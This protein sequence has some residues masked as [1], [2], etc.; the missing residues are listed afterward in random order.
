MKRK[1]AAILSVIL[2]LCQFLCCA[3]AAQTSD[4]VI[5]SAYWTEDVLYTFVQFPQEAPEDLEVSLFVNNSRQEGKAHPASLRDAG[6][7]VHVMLLVDTSSSMDIYAYYVNTFAQNLMAGCGGLDITV[8]SM[9][10]EFRIAATGLT[11]WEDAQTTL[12]LLDYRYDGSDICGGTAKALEYL[13]EMDYPAGELCSLVVITDGVPWYSNTPEVEAEREEQAAAAAAARM[14]M[15]PEVLVNTLCLRDWEEKTFAA[16]SAGRGLHLTAGASIDAGNAGKALADCL[17][18]LYTVT[19]PLAGYADT[20]RIT[21]SVQLCVENSWFSVGNIRN[22]DMAPVWG[23]EGAVEIPPVEV[24]ETQDGEGAE[25]PFRQLTGLDTEG[26][27]ISAASGQEEQVPRAIA[28]IVGVG[29][30]AA[31]VAIGIL[32]A[33]WILAKRKHAASIRMQV[34]I[35][36]EGAVRTKELHYLRKELLIGTGKQCDIVIREPQA[37]PVNT[38]IYKQ[39]PMIYVEDMGSPQGTVLNGMRIFSSNRLRSEDEITIGGTVLRFLF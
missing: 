8:A 4:P 34:E 32:L 33:V 9:G 13:G 38:R 18:S 20:A 25:S 21:D 23:T 36:S 11:R 37:A 7:A 5:R 22:L 19:F 29:I 3:A 24:S 10:T 2:L 39:G 6:G 26:W 16:L 15:Y 30:A 27:S 12:R 17:D 35:L 14:D 1:I 31:A 28:W